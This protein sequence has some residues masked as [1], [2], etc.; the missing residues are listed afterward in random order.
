[1]KIKYT[2]IMSL[3]ICGASLFGR[4]PFVLK[5]SKGTDPFKNPAPLFSMRKTTAGLAQ[6]GALLQSEKRVAQNADGEKNISVKWNITQMA[7]LN[8]SFQGEY[9]FHKKMSVGLGFSRLL[10]R[11]VSVLYGT[12][13]NPYAEHFSSP[14]MSGFALTP[15]F[16]FY[17]G[18]NDEKPAPQGFYLGVYARYSKYKITQ[19]VSYTDDDNGTPQTYSAESNQTYGGIQGGWLIGKQWIMGGGFTIDY[20][21]VGAGYGKGTY[22]YEWVVPGANLTQAQQ[23]DVKKQAD[24][25]FDNF[26]AAGLD[27]SVTTTNNSAKMTVKGLPLASF[28]MGLCLGW[29]F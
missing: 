20:W 21:I 3:L 10:K 12:K 17:F 22:S 23:E 24:E 25:N 14:L 1:M 29:S 4:E 6:T 8:L 2:L 19:V 7:F 27:A 11:D 18:G 13:D 15:E 9:G 16:R 28:R 5:S 26:S